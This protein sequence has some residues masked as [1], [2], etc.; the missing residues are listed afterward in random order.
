M[1]APVVDLSSVEGYLLNLYEQGERIEMLLSQNTELIL[2]IYTTLLWGVG[3]TGTL[4]VIFVLY[5]FLR[6]FF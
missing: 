2:H 3:V 6:K 1:E 4:L 5:K